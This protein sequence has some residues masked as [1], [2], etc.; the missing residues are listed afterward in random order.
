MFGQPGALPAA[1]RRLFGGDH[2]IE[3]QRLAVSPSCVISS[4]LE[5]G[6]AGQVNAGRRAIPW[7][8]IF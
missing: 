3:H 8:S 5:G 6:L 7:R 4:E 1:H 2:L